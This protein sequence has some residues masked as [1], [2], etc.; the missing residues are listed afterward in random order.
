[1]RH[2]SIDTTLRYYVGQNAAST[3]EAVFRSVGR[4]EGNTLG[5]SVADADGK[6]RSGIAVNRSQV[7][8]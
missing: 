4:L 2:A 7:E 1:M 6:S 8:D 3:A 5:N